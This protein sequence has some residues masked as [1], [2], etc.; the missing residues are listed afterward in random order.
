MLEITPAEGLTVAPVNII[1]FGVPRFVWLIMLKN[2]ARNCS[3]IRSEIWVFLNTEKS[4]SAIPGPLN[5]ALPEFP[6]VPTVGNMY[7]FGLNHWFGDPMIT[8]PVKAGF[9][10]GLSGLLPSPFPERLDPSW[11][12][13][14]NPLSKVT[15]P[16]NCQPPASLSAVPLNPFSQGFARPMGNS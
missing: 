3:P 1:G 15:M 16:F 6:K 11:G 5:T 4:S 12:V 9:I 13:K 10:E 8:G 7:A 2:S 14:G